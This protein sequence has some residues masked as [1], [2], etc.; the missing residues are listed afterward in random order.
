MPPKIFVNVF[1]FSLYNYSHNFSIYLFVF[2]CIFSI[3]VWL[4][5]FCPVYFPFITNPFHHFNENSLLFFDIYF[6]AKQLILSPSSAILGENS[7]DA[8]IIMCFILNLFV[9]ASKFS[10]Y[11]TKSSKSPASIVKSN[12]QRVGTCLYQ[13]ECKLLLINCEAVIWT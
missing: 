9:F 7:S 3:F 2:L 8:T 11:L 5:N 6:S 1:V 4:H 10:V 13:E 12:K